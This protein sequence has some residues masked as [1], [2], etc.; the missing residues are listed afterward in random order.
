MSVCFVERGDHLLGH[1]CAWKNAKLPFAGN[2]DLE[3]MLL[4]LSYGKAN[5]R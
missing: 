3:L 2:G 1:A 4:F 5:G